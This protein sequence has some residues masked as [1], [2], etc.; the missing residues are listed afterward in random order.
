M[1]HAI[2]H[3]IHTLAGVHQTHTGFVISYAD[4]RNVASPVTI[5]VVF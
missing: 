3:D 1:L 5:I 4:G 2:H